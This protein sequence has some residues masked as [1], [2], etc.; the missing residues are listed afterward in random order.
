MSL[1]ASGYTSSDAIRVLIVP[2]S[3]DPAPAAAPLQQ[4]AEQQQQQHRH[5]PWRRPRQ[6]QSNKASD[7]VGSQEQCSKRP[8]AAAAMLPKQQEAAAAEQRRYGLEAVEA[9]AIQRLVWAP[10]GAP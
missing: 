4:G 7:G 5:Q 10:L 3:A 6:L 8:A 1:Q 2:S 9:G